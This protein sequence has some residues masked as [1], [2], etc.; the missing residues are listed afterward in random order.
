M[1]TRGSLELTLTAFLYRNE[2]LAEMMG[3]SLG[4]F[5]DHTIWGFR[6]RNSIKTFPRVCHVEP[7]AMRGSLHTTGGATWYTKC[8]V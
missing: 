6:A 1:L 3:H 2:T 8:Q 7:Q 4:K 5:A